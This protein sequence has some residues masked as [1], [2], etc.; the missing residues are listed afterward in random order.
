MLFEILA[1]SLVESTNMILMDLRRRFPGTR[2]D[3]VGFVWRE[4]EMWILYDGTS[5]NSE[6]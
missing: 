1:R 3:L 2:D 4:R 5:G 6:L